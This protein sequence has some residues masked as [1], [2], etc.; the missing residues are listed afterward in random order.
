LTILALRTQLTP[1]QLDY[2]SKIKSSAHALLGIVN[3]MLDFSK[4]EAGKLEIE[5]TNFHL[6]RVL[7]NLSNVVTLKAE[8]KGLEILFDIGTDVPCALKGDPLR[9]EQVLSNLINN[10]I[11]F[12]QEG[13]ILV[14]VGIEEQRENRVTLKF[15][16]KDT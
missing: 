6:E 3:D 7:K 11:K 9:L 2:L 5:Q 10:A 13:E 12:T 15:A 4:I 1:K 16:I 8:E 14:S